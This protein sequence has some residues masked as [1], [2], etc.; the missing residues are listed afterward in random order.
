MDG[1][2][3]MRDVGEAEGNVS[4]VDN[5]PLAPAVDES[6]NP[7]AISNQM[8]NEEDEMDIDVHRTAALGNRYRFL[9]LTAVL[10]TTT[11]CALPTTCSHSK[12]TSI[13]Y[14]L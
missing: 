7:R 6:T 1:D 14:L 9:P 12:L 2:T 13:I 5:R 8:I 4:D 3:V 10:L 11:Y